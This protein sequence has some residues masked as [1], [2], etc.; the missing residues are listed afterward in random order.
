MLVH[1]SDN[2]WS[3]KH[4][5]THLWWYLT[6]CINQSALVDNKL[7]VISDYQCDIVSNNCGYKS[8]EQ[9]VTGRAKTEMFSQ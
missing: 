9:R 4:S 6:M 1:S 8:E 5:P 7:H 3:Q 2:L